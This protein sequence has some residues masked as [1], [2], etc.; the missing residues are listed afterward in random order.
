MHQTDSRASLV[1]V[2]YGRS[3]VG[4]AKVTQMTV[5]PEGADH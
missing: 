5:R 2:C 4:I 1:K 3:C